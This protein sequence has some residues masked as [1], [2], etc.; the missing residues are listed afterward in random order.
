MRN[1]FTLNVWAYVQGAG[2]WST[3]QVIMVKLG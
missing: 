1:K 3:R 2:N